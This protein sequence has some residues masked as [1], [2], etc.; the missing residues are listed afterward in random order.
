[1]RHALLLAPF[2]LLLA[3]CGLKPLYSGGSGG[4]VAAT[5]SN[6]EVAPIDGKSGWLMTNA[7]RDR[8]AA[9]GTPQYRLD[10]RLDDSIAGFGVRRD[11]SVTR[12]R[13]TL[14]ARYQLV[15][16]TD[17]SVLIDA[18]AGSDAGIDVVQSEYATIA[19]ENTALERLSGIV[20]DQI[21][22]RIALYAQRRPTP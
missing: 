8:L 2:A 9:D 5:L 19:A 17:G 15:N 14:R 7:L 21:V 3:G 4:S 16:L 1:M 11:D 10:V 6:V 18:T 22:A 20:A 13:R 12:E